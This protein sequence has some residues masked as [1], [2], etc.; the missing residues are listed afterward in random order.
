MIHELRT[1]GVLPGKAAAYLELSGSVGRPVRG[2]RFGKLVGYFSTEAGPLNQVVHLWEYADLAARAQARAGLAKD[3]RW[4]TEYIPKSQPLLVW[5]ENVIL[6]P[7]DWYPLKPATGMGLYELRT[8][9]C[10][11]GKVPEWAGLAREALPIREKYS[12]PVGY[13]QVEVGPLNT[14]V[15]L[16]PYRDAQH[17]AEVRKAVAADAGW[18]AIM[19]RAHPLIQHQESKL[20]VPASFSPLR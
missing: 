18:Q 15:H 19:S 8:Y 16:W 6:S 14:V 1:Y 5:Q 9:R 3:E 7:M 20:L 11:P 2:D 10:H 13:W 12:S 4:R 17:R